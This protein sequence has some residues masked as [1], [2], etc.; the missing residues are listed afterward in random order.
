MSTLEKAVLSGDNVPDAHSQRVSSPAGVTA[1]AKAVLSPDHDC[2]GYVARKVC[3][4][5]ELSVQKC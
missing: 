4:F 1:D 2:W 3:I 5:I